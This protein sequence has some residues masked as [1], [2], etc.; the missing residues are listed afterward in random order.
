MFRITLLSVFIFLWAKCMA[1]EGA[2][3]FTLESPFDTVY[4]NLYVNDNYLRIDEKASNEKEIRQITIYNRKTKTI[5]ALS[6]ERKQYV[7]IPYSADNKLENRS[8]FE[9][10]PS[11]NF[12]VLFNKR[13]MQ[14]RVKNKELQTEVVYWLSSGDY[15]FFAEFMNNH[16][17]TDNIRDFFVYI[18]NNEKYLPMI[19][20]ER[21]LTRTLKHRL[22]VTSIT[23]KKIE[24]SFFAIPSS[25][26]QVEL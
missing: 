11:T 8:S 12:K 1:F 21:T 7:L 9:I 6:P 14:W 22:T 26:Y 3:A 10:I 24:N 16:R 4:Y 23:N 5:N 15:S 17:R 13:C 18:P 19:A 25:Y 20:E 2:I